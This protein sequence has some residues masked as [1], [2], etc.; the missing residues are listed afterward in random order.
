[1]HTYQQAQ[2]FLQTTKIPENTR[3]GRAARAN[4]TQGNHGGFAEL[5]TDTLERRLLG[6]MINQLRG[7]PGDDSPSNCAS[8]L[9]L[10]TVAYDSVGTRY[11]DGSGDSRRY[12][13]AIEVL[14]SILISMRNGEV[15]LGRV[16]LLMLLQGV[17]TYTDNIFV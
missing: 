17:D 13:A 15:A 12:R 6:Q 1:M 11:T 10:T 9:E 16:E 2:D 7:G 5:G 3:E 4:D 8:L 14:H